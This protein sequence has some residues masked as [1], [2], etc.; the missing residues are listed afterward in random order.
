MKGL[1]K[2]GRPLHQAD[3]CPANGGFSQAGQAGRALQFKDKNKTS[4][5]LE[6]RPN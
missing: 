6:I 5:I 3:P 4:S 1:S 2:Y